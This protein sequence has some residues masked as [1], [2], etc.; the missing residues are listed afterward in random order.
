VLHLAKGNYVEALDRFLKGGFWMDAAYVAERVLTVEELKSYVDGAWPEQGS[1]AADLALS[2]TRE[3]IR[4]LLARRLVRLC[5][6][7]R[8]YF[9][10]ECRAKHDELMANLKRGETESLSA[11]ERAAGW[12]E[13]AKMIR[14]QG[15]ELIGTELE[16]DWHIRGGNSGEDVGVTVSDRATNAQAKVLVA[17]TDE[18][19]RARRH[20]ADPEARFHYRYQAAFIALQAASLLPDNS[21]EKARILCT[22]G[23]WLKAQDAI[24]ADI[25]YKYLVRRCRKTA[26]GNAADVMR[27]F[28]SQDAN[29][30]FQPVLPITT[31]EAT[32]E[33]NVEPEAT[34][35]TPLLIE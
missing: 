4:F 18:L 29:G 2:G 11:E 27:W 20:K 24:T 13:G 23:S 1:D 26:L 34:G 33:G 25:F 35:E 28:P 7:A 15:L 5:L 31:D 19:S 3:A 10:A 32:P 14:Q 30:D 9:P 8:A 6:P 17:S 22:A 21:D 12:W 16:P